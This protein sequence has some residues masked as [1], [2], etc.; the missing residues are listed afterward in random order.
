MARTFVLVLVLVLVVV[1]AFLVSG[2]R[3][4]VVV[5]GGGNV[6]V[7]TLRRVRGIGVLPP[8]CGRASAGS[9]GERKISPASEGGA[10]GSLGCFGQ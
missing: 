4:A 7:A 8:F 1:A 5:D 6:V 3:L 10:G 2:L 9:G